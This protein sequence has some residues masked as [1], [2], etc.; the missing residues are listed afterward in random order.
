MKS[1]QALKSLKAMEKT[2]SSIMTLNYGGL[3]YGI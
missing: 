1:D 2:Q 3:N